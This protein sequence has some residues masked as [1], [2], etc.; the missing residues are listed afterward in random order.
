MRKPLKKAVA[1]TVLA[2]MGMS[3]MP[4]WFFSAKNAPKAASFHAEKRLFAA[5]TSEDAAAKAQDNA[6]AEVSPARVLVHFGL[7][8]NGVYRKSALV[9][10][11]SFAVSSSL[12][13][14]VKS[15]ENDRVA[16]RT[17]GGLTLEYT[18]LSKLL[19]RR[20]CA[21]APGE[22]LGTAAGLVE[23][24][25]ELGGRSL[26]PVALLWPKMSRF[27][28]EAAR[29]EKERA[30]ILKRIRSARKY[31]TAAPANFKHLFENAA[32]K[33]NTD[34]RLLEAVA[35]A[36]SGFNPQAVSPKGALGLMQLMP[37]VAR[38]LGVSDP[39]D[40]AQ[41]V[42]AGAEYLHDMLDRFG[43]LELALAA[44]NAGPAAV[45]KYGGVP[46]YPETQAYIQK[47][48]A[49]YNNLEVKKS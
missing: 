30:K 11:D 43:D 24:R 34:S 16:L 14:T 19:V 32:K 21:A 4:V 41:N 17:A 20:G 3:V 42:R 12:P 37:D 15:A 26:D 29:V 45:E 2:T 25:A 7:K 18:G 5:R 8:A 9:E 47:V 1:V 35:A 6:S 38:S 23:V 13:G 10:F 27:S 48:L 46:P 28:E 22:A 33:T 31:R 36:E 39:F 40:P 44:Y 49:I